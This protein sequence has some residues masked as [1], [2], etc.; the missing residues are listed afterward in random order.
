M[1]QDYILN[2]EGMEVNLLY[3][4]GLK[5]LF[6]TFIFSQTLFNKKRPCDLCNYVTI[7]FVNGK[8]V[9]L[10]NNIHTFS[11]YKI[12]RS[13]KNEKYKILLMRTVD[14][15]AYELNMPDATKNTNH[16]HSWW[17]NFHKEKPKTKNLMHIVTD[18]KLRPTGYTQLLD[19][20]F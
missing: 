10:Y 20:M 2:Y 11:S 17:E 6:F 3:W 12:F 19:E 14:F 18:T 16:L 5:Y 1:S 9:Y 13:Q 4:S 8:S 15:F 7:R